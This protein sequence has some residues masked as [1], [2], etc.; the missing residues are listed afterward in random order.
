VLEGFHREI[1][2]GYIYFAVFFSLIVEVFNMRVRKH[3]HPVR[4]HKEL[5][6]KPGDLV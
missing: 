5:P 3:T 4:L 1:P 2:K 6:E